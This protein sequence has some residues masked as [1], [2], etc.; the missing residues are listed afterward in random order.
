MKRPLNELIAHG[1]VGGILA[2]L[3]LAVWFLVVEPFNGQALHTPAALAS[4]LSHPPIAT[5][6]FRLV[7]A[8]TVVH[9]GVFA[10]VGVIAAW[11]LDTLQ[12]R[13]G[14]LFGILFGIV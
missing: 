2:G 12:L 8:Y 13:A 3:V 5:P 4:A 11:A 6:P 14:L 1:V 10:C 9:F 7:A